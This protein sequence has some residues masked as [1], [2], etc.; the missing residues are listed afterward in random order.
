MSE[1]DGIKR[2]FTG[3]P[4]EARYICELMDEAGIGVMLRNTL[5]ESLIAGWASGSPEDAVRVFV[6]DHDFDKAMKI[7][8]DYKNS[9]ENE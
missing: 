2:I 6:A 7:V 5:N 3:S 9:E 8:D 4:V 1:Q